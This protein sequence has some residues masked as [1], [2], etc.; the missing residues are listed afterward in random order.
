[1][2]PQEEGFLLLYSRVQ[3]SVPVD[4][5]A[6]YGQAMSSALI[7]ESIDLPDQSSANIG[8]TIIGASAGYQHLD[9]KKTFFRWCELWIYKPSPCI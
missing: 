2:L 6:L 5:P 9:K 7:L 1:M 3:F 8:I 4:I